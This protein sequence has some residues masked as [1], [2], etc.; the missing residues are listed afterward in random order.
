M[1]Q[2]KFYEIEYIVINILKIV[3]N[4]CVYYKLKNNPLNLVRF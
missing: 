3:K 2:I 1:A 4:C